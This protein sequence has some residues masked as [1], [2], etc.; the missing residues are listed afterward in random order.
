MGALVLAAQTAL[1]KLGYQ[2]KADGNDGL[3]T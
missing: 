2:V 3:A 1:V